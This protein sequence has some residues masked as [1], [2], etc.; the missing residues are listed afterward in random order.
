MAFYTEYSA[1]VPYSTSVITHSAMANA[2]A[3]LLVDHAG[4]TLVIHATEGVASSS[5]NYAEITRDG[6]Y[7][8]FYSANTSYSYYLDAYLA[9]S[10]NGTSVAT[11]SYRFFPNGSTSVSIM[12][13]FY[14]TKS[15]FLINGYRYDS[16]WELL[17][18][19][20]AC[21]KISTGDSAFAI[22]CSYSSSSAFLISDSLGA[23]YYFPF[24]SAYYAGIY[25]QDAGQQILTQGSTGTSSS[26]LARRH[27]LTDTYFANAFIISG[28]IFQVTSRYFYQP[29][30]TYYLAVELNS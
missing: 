11:A 25:D 27:W 24:A 13:R 12:L 29:G 9:Y 1:I 2:L 23:N 14:N 18:F 22:G 5:T 19:G 7:I 10:S 3:D 26:G 20:F 16:T 21:S 30:A 28:G 6:I 8:R 4:F 15:G 17:L